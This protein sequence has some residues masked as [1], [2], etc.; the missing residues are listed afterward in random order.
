MGMGSISSTFYVQSFRT[1]IILAV[2][3]SV[4]VTREK[5]PKQRS[6]ENFVRKMLMK[7]TTGA[8]WM[9]LRNS[10]WQLSL[11]FPSNDLPSRLL[12]IHLRIARE[13]FK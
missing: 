6:Y 12:R 4:H 8:H 3:F 2:F 11:H 1:N 5:L 9:D 10:G 13:A 7:L